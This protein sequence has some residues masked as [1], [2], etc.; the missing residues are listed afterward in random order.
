M[1]LHKNKIGFDEE[2]NLVTIHGGTMSKYDCRAI[3]DEFSL[4][5]IERAPSLLSTKKKEELIHSE[6][7]LDVHMNT[8]L[9]YER[10]RS[11][12]EAR[13]VGYCVE[14]GLEGDSSNVR[15]V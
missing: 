6:E 3:M 10:Y 13:R 2:A 7:G 12:I 15:G 1:T 4:K 5:V 8:F 11:C 9:N 14:S